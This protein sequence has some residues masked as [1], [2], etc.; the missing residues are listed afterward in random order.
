M[1]GSF[2]GRL[3]GHR[4]PDDRQRGQGGQAGQHVPADDLR[5]DRGLYRVGGLVQIVGAVGA[6]RAESAIEIGQVG[7]PVRQP[8]IV[9]PQ[10]RHALIERRGVGGRREE[11]VVRASAGGE[12]DL[13]DDDA[14]H[15]QRRTQSRGR[16]DLGPFQLGLRAQLRTQ[17]RADAHAVIPSQGEGRQHLAGVRLAGH[18]PGQQRHHPRQLSRRHL[19][20]QEVSGVDRRVARCA[21]H[22]VAIG[23]DRRRHRRNVQAACSAAAASSRC[24]R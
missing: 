13:G 8:H 19:V 3:P 10:Q 6:Q 21:A 23:H 16:L 5:A 15:P 24:T 18:P 9:G 2:G 11:V 7:V 22:G 14:H 20:D 4:L 12:L 17:D 1:I